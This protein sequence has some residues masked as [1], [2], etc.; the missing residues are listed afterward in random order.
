MP[1]FI[2]RP[3][4]RILSIF[5]LLF[6]TACQQL[7]VTQEQ[8]LAG[9][10][11]LQDNEFQP[12]TTPVESEAQIF[13]LPQTVVEQARQ[14]VLAYQYADER[15][16]ALL[17]FIFGSDGDPLEY[18]NNATL[19]ATDTYEKK[20][21]NCLSLT[22][23][24]YSLAQQLGFDAYFQDVDVPEY[25][26]TRSGN[27]MLN[28]H[29][30]LMIYP[31]KISSSVQQIVV[32]R[33]NGYL[34]D[35]DMAPQ[36]AKQQAKRISEQT[37]VA[38][39][40]NNKAA[41]AMMNHQYDLAYHYLKAA[42]AKAPQLAQNWNNLAVLYRKKELLTQA[43][44]VY[45]YSLRLEPEHT[46]TMS[47]LAM[48]YELTG[49]AQEAAVL[50]AKVAKKRLSN[51]YFFIM[52][53]NEALERHEADDAIKHFRR[54]LKLQPHV[55]EAYFGL[56]RS[57]LLKQDLVKAS[58]YLQTAKR[59]SDSATEQRRYQYKLDMLNAVAKQD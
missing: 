3:A 7:P 28:G 57:Y 32:L 10:L 43:E 9:L 29:V 46:N 1:L 27:S 11:L 51:P 39:F 24:A 53:G 36:R 14:Q 45:L 33:N 25:W 49:R 52:Q 5:L 56:A 21:A 40:Y 48:L 17:T 18:V 58:G 23:L 19:T 4:I 42:I 34:I 2:H 38:M 31:T 50:D 37:I 47:N 41:D 20:Q 16:L 44:Q 54:S 12:V 35:F 15:S 6:L 22:I 30:N 26:V 8:Q 59:Y 13:A 55:P